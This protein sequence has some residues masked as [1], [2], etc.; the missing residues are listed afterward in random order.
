MILL[1]FLSLS[2]ELSSSLVTESTLFCSH[3]LFVL[4]SSNKLTFYSRLSVIW[5]PVI[6]TLA[7][8]NNQIK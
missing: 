6:W 7:Y 1:V 2:L 5:T 4:N 3:G 8:M